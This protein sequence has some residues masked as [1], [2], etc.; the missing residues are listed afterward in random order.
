[1]ADT[2]PTA[3]ALPVKRFA[4]KAFLAY[5]LTVGL[6]AIVAAL[7]LVDVPES[8]QQ[9][10]GPIITAYVT[11]WVG[12]MAYYF[13]SSQGSEDKNKTIEAALHNGRNP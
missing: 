6:L 3:E 11:A 1:M 13:G 5:S 2:E 10:I 8:N 4:F 12:S 9:V 7:F